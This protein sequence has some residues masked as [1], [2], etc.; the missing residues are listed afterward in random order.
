M[1]SRSRPNTCWAYLVANGRPVRA[2]VTTI[3]RSKTPEQIRMNASRSRW[4]VSMPGLH[5]EHERAE[6]VGERAAA[7]VG[8]RLV[9]RW[10]RQADQGVEQG[11]DA[12]VRDGGREQHRR[13]HAVQEQG[14]LVVG[15]GGLQQLDLLH[16]LLPR[17]ALAGGRRLGGEGLLRRDG[18]P[19][20]GAGEPAVGAVGAVEH[21]AEV[22]GD[23]D[24]PGERGRGEAGPLG[25][26]VHELEGVLARTVPLVDDGEH[27]DAAV[28]ADGEQLHGLGLEALGGVDQHHGGVDGGEDPV[29]VLGEVRVARG[30]EQVDD[31][32]AVLELQGRRG[33]GDAAVALH[34]HPVRHGAAA[35]GLAVDGAGLADHAGVQRER[36]GQR[37]LAGVR[38]ADDGEGAAPAGLPEHVCRDAAGNRLLVECAHR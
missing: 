12:E 9:R 18:G 27:R 8:V 34:V 26:L 6:R 19:A 14:L 17:V 2:C 37:G 11:A 30:V 5:L 35:A 28:P 38:V 16:R 33:D 4:A 29:G 1:L 31:G 15:A 24:R 21:P 10:R 20:G 13:R 22:T 7:A 36:L 3:P 23:A 32:V 25:D